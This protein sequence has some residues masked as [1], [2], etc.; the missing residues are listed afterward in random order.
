MSNEQ[1]YYELTMPQKSILYTEEYFDNTSINNVSGVIHY[2]ENMNTNILK[3]AIEYMYTINESLRIRIVKT[4]GE[5]KQ[6]F[7]DEKNIVDIIKVSEEDKDD[8]IRSLCRKPFKLID[9][10]LAKFYI[11]KYPNNRVDVVSV[12]HHIICDAWTCSMY[13]NEIARLYYLFSNNEQVSETTFPYLNFIENEKEYLNSTNFDNDKKYWNDEFSVEPK[14]Q[15]F[16]VTNNP[17]GKRTSYTINE[18]YTSK[19]KNFCKMYGISE[20]CLF[21]S[22]ISI[23]FAKFSSSENIAIGMPVLNRKNKIDKQT[24]GMFIQTLPLFLNIKRDM[25]IIDFIKFIQSKQFSFLKHHRYP[26]EYLQKDIKE[27]FDTTQKLYTVAFSYQN[28]KVDND[29]KVKCDIEWIFNGYCADDIQIHIDDRNSTNCFHVN[30]DYKSS[31]FDKNDID[32]IYNRIVYIIEQIINNSNILIKDIK[33]ITDEEQRVI[34]GFNNTYLNYP[35]DKTIVEVINNIALKNP[36]EIAVVDCNGS[37]LTYKQL[38]Y[39][40]DFLVNKL[41]ALDIHKGDVVSIYLSEKTTYLIISILAVLKLGAS[42][43][44]LYNGLPDERIKYIINDSKSKLIIADN[45]NY[46]KFND[47]TNFNIEHDISFEDFQIVDAISNSVEKISSMDE[48]TNLASSQD[49]AYMI[50]TSGTTG[51]PKGIELTNKNLV[52][53]VYSFRN[54]F[55]DDI[56]VGDKFLSLTNVSFDVCISELF[57]PLCFGATLYLYKDISTVTVDELCKFI[58]DNKIT[59]S[60]FPPSM[61]NE[62]SDC[63]IKYKDELVLNKMLVGVEPITHSTL[64]K[65][66]NI[67]PN[68]KIINGY[69]PSETT[70]CSTMYNFDPND[71][72]YEIVTIGGPINNTKIHIV[73]SDYNELPVGVAGELFISGD[74]VGK[75]YK[76]NSVLNSEKYILFNG[77][78]T[79]KSGDIGKWDKNGNIVFYGRNDN[80]IKFRGYR[81]DLGEIENTLKSSND[82]KNAVLILDK[83]LSSE[84]KLIAFVILQ[85]SSIVEE[86]LRDFLAKTLPYYMLPSKFIKLDA[87]PMTANGKID[88]KKLL[89]IATNLRNEEKIVLPENEIEQKIYDVIKSKL[90]YDNLSVNDNFFDIGLDSLEAISLS[91]NLKELGYDFSL[92]DFYNSPTIRLLANKVQQAEPKTQ[93]VNTDNYLKEFNIN[94]RKPTSIDG[95]ILLFGATGFLGSHL[96]FELIN[97]TDR[98]IYCLVRGS[99][100]LQAV[101]RLKAKLDFY[102]NEDFYEK[103]KSRIVVLKGNFTETNFGL[104]A[105][106]Y[107]LVLNDTTMII[108]SAACVKHFG[109][110]QYFYDVNFS[111]VKKSIDFCLANQK[112]FVHI[113]TMSILRNCNTS[114]TLSEKTLYNK[115]NLDNIYI[116]T[117]FDAEQLI[118]NFVDYGLSTTVFRLGNI[119]CRYS[120]GKFQE[121]ENENSFI[122]K[123]KTIIKY[124]AVPKSLLSVKVDLS[125]VDLCAKSIVSILN[126]NNYNMYH[127]ENN[128]KITIRHL[129]FYLRRLGYKIDVMSDEDYSR[130]ILS[131]SDNSDDLFALME[132]PENDVHINSKITLK[133]LKSCKFKWNRIDK[134]YIKFLL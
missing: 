10:P 12:S 49:V 24:M 122:L 131:L 4:E 73:N 22:A 100:K 35:S 115:Q 50:Y 126:N 69:G 99:N 40:S 94:K 47:I 20:Q 78:P 39:Y 114:D 102:F 7:S 8:L 128:H 25:N 18:N 33:L 28:A 56:N 13:T 133:S 45:F 62:V 70:I 80:Q 104:S 63:F 68:L 124:K 58:A 2:T 6:Y 66:T 64:L 14:T 101:S 87:F 96:L 32:E 55:N 61:L 41:K 37:S 27:K 95:N 5:Y 103:N 84:D 36:L 110:K 42:F 29:I 112:H 79:F 92:Q 88:K 57:T 34:D 44:L 1:K 19:I 74:G 129:V 127:I 82:V 130:K 72:T 67:L 134:K 85:D 38:N 16:N 21:M 15:F 77:L 9:S 17:A 121:N 106:D 76:N 3:K 118:A 109:N 91:V 98:T 48:S 23:Y 89:E 83:Q 86:T 51:N 54:K 120:D 119:M 93:V 31:L 30:F 97:S 81:I 52:N 90:E 116:A 113:S 108:N 11:L 117:K 60:Y 107:N 132:K 75:G 125:P 105:L 123:L 59:F 65:F 26:Y 46:N 43:I 111:S 71:E 53:F